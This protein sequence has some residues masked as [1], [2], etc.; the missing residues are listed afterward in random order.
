M[1]EASPLVSVIVVN[2]NAG[3]RIRRMLDCL[4]AQTFRNFEIIIIDNASTDG[5]RHLAD[6]H[7]SAPVVID[8]G[9][10]LGFAAASNR[11]AA[12]AGGVFLAF[13]NPDAYPR[14]EWLAH[15]VAAA[16][17]YPWADAF[18]S[19]QINA[20]NPAVIDGAGDVFHV[21]GV[22]YRGHFGWSVEKMP[23]EGE[24]FAAC[25]AA[26]LYRAE[27]FRT[28]GGFEEGFFC[29][30]EDVDLGFRLRLRG[31]STIQVADA[32][33]LHE[34]SGITG[35]VSDFTVYHGHRN[36]IWTT[37]RCMPGLLYWPL[38][39]VRLAADLYLLARSPASGTLRPYWR[40]LRDGYGRLGQWRNTRR[41]LQ[42]E[43]RVSL[44]SLAR[45][46]EWSPMKISRRE[47]ALRPIAGHYR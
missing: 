27:A 29:Y 41:R 21:L 2:Y 13:L 31:G 44:L 9:S 12:R 6:E 25:A 17:R 45:M 11:A 14:P 36:R 22:P 40:A 10:N 46:L 43:R 38:F 3:A 1:I 24:C 4:A 15:L 34:G 35:R 5:S 39:P 33:V 19:A 32:I 30:G 7:T 28:L 20:G 18:G 26:A 47:A 23:A 16:D 37:Y 8:A 42:K